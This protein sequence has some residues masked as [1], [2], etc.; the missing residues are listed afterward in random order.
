MA[1]S[2][3]EQRNSNI[4][5]LDASNSM[6][7]IAFKYRFSCQTEKNKYALFWSTLRKL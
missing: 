5:Q 2:K 6:E 1:E 3:I 7:A 4:D